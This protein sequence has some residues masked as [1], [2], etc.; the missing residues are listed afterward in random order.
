MPKSGA[1]IVLPAD[2]DG[3]AQAGQI[4][5][6]GG[7]VAFPTETVYG[8]GADALAA[9]AVR[10]IFEA[11]GRPAEDP[12]IV[13]VASA[14]HVGR[15]A[16][17]SQLADR[18]AERFWPGPLTLVLEKTSA[19]PAEATAGL[20][21]VAVRVPAHRVAQALLQ[22]ADQPIAAPS[23]N[24][25]SRPSPTRVEH[26]LE[27]LN[28]RIDAILDGGPTRLGLESTIVDVSGTHPRLLRPG[29]LAVEEIEAVLGTPLML[30]FEP[31]AGPRLAPG[32]MP[33]HYAPRTPLVLI[34]GEP[35]PAR[36]RL[37]R[38]VAASLARGERV[39]VLLLE[40]DR[41]LLGAS[42]K[43]ARMGSWAD[44]ESSAVRLFDA[45]R[46]LDRAGLDVLFSRE[47]ADSRSGLGR[48]LADRLRRAASRVVD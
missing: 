28:G 35:G 12:L 44:A 46:E 3:V 27:D 38:E 37:K 22:A 31:Q 15:V 26:V 47:L 30:G 40:D 29:G 20:K 8:L 14:A 1:T 33:M 16:I 17:L 13:H 10:K 18:L 34:A 4:L 19:V 6:Q 11:K 45:L 43:T 42:V 32:L 23:A 9:T 5:R 36:A 25:F 48:A 41:H 21:T 39:G 24:L 7:L 2:A